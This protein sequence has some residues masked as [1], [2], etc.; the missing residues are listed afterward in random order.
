[1][2]ITNTQVFPLKGT[3]GKLKAFARITLDGEL[4]LS[5]LR[6][7]DSVNGLFVSYPADLNHKGEDYRH[8]YSPVTK[9][10]RQLIQDTVIKVYNEITNPIELRSEPELGAEFSLA[11]A[12]AL[13]TLY[14]RGE[15]KQIAFDDNKMLSL[16]AFITNEICFYI[17]SDENL[18][19]VYEN[20][21]WRV[22]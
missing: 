15:F 4:M 3:E 8:Y 6:V 10:F 13:Q 18:E 20:G 11:Q 2:E 12:D 21:D 22:L 7:Y 16:H 14:P 5:S 1:M 17:N 9:E 19:E